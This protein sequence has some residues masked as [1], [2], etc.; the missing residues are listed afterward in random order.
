MSAEQI[1]VDHD[2]FVTVAISITGVLFASLGTLSFLLGKNVLNRIDTKIEN[3][4]SKQEDKMDSNQKIINTKLDTLI[5]YEMTNRKSIDH[6]H[7][8]ITDSDKELNN[9]LAAHIN[10]FHTKD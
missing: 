3:G 6:A 10:K 1:I 9:K 7:N 5:D 8:R 4:H 2:L